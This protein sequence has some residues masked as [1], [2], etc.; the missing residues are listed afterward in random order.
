MPNPVPSMS[1]RSVLHGFGGTLATVHLIRLRN[2]LPSDRPGYSLLQH[3]RQICIVAFDAAEYLTSRIFHDVGARVFLIIPSI[4]H[5]RAR[6]GF[7]CPLW[8]HWRVCWAL[9]QLEH[10]FRELCA[11][12]RD[13]SILH[14]VGT[15]CCY[16]IWLYQ[17]Q[18]RRTG[19][20]DFPIMDNIS[21][22]Y[23]NGRDCRN[24]IELLEKCRKGCEFSKT[25]DPRIHQI[26]PLL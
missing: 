14:L 10:E 2:M 3:L 18:I 5:V 16:A 15:G 21:A 20:R 25:S 13:G 6:F 17:I 8:Q 11:E 9:C 23:S 4:L 12:D 1:C 19:R 22:W 26:S 24:T 7:C